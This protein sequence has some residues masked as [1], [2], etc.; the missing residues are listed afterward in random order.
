MND[1]HAKF[2]EIFRRAPPTFVMMGGRVVDYDTEE[3]RA[4]VTW[5]AKPE[6]GNPWG[7]VQGGILA[8][9]LDDTAAIAGVVKTGG[10]VVFPTLE[11]KTSFLKP[12]KIGKLIAEGRV[13]KMGYS[14]AFL[15]AEIFDDEGDVV[16]R[17][18]VTAKLRTLNRAADD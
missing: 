18:S 15:E 13:V 8:A 12:A 3:G 10:K 1:P 16:A 17:M 11:F 14:V 4:T 9:M 5:E 2:E 6:F 7:V